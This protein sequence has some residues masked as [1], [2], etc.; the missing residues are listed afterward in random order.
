MS[1]IK[2]PLRT[3]LRKYCHVECYDPQLIK[4][5]IKNGEGFP[6]NVDLLKNQLRE[7]IDKKLISP[8]EYED[9]TEEDFDSQE[10]LQAWLEEFL[11]ELP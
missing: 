9:L 6:Y 5:A 3:V 2:E 10:D 1:D 11:A 7:A 4:E 8:N